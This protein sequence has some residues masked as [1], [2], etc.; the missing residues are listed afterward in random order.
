MEYSKL[1]NT[2]LDVSKIC[3]GCMSFGDPENW[4]HD[5]LLKEDESRMIIKKAIDLGI[6]FFDTAN[7]YSLGVSE[8]YL[9]RAK[10]FREA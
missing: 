4:M 8:E 9:G 5:W 1:G 10:R 7:I 6:N 3:L 2:G